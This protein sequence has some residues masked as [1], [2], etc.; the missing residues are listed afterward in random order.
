L[1]SAK[2]E[3]D[4]DLYGN[5]RTIRNY[6]GHYGDGAVYFDNPLFNRSP[7]LKAAQPPTQTLPA[8][9]KLAQL[10]FKY[11]VHCFLNKNTFRRILS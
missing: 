6:S 10:R 5:K 4:C 8:V 7:P 3:N 1:V 9:D 11:P 2:P